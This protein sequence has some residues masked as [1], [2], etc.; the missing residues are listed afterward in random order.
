MLPILM[1]LDWAASEM[2]SLVVSP[3]GVNY[4]ALDEPPY[5]RTLST[6]PCYRTKDEPPSYRV[7][8]HDH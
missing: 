8:S 6:P 2:V 1:Q 7:V 5:Y 4:R 3:A